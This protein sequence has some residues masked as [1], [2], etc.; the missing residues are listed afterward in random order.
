[1]L[2]S[3][4]SQLNQQ[5]DVT[6]RNGGRIQNDGQLWFGAHQEHA[7]GLEV[8]MTIY[9]GTVDL[10]GGSYPQDNDGIPIVADLAFFY[11]Y[12]FNADECNGCT[13]NLA[14]KNERHTIN[15]KGPGS[16][17]VDES[18]IWIWEQDEPTSPAPTPAIWNG[19][20][21]TYEQLWDRGI[22][23]SGGVSGGD[24]GVNIAGHFVV[25]G[26]AGANDYVVT[27]KDPVAV[28]WD[29]GNGGWD[30]ANWNTGQT[31]SS[32][33]TDGRG[34]PGGHA[35]SIGGGAQVTY[36]AGAIR[37]L[38]P[39]VEN[40]PASITVKEGASLTLASVDTDVDGVWTQYDADLTLDN[41]TFA[42]T[43]GGSSLSGGLMMLG[44]W[45]SRPGQQIDVSVVN[46][47]S[48]EN[49]GQ[50]WFGAHQEH[51]PGLEVTMTINNGSVELTGGSYP[52]DNDGIPIVADLAFFYGY[53]FNADECNGCSANLAAKNEQY[54]INFT[55]PGSIS[56]DESGIWI[57]EQDEPTSPAPTPAIWNGALATYQELW[58]RGILQANGLSGLTGAMF[59]T[60]FSVTGTAG[61]NDYT[62]T[63]LIAPPGLDGDF[64]GDGKVDT[65]DYVVWRKTD[66]MQPGYDEWRANFGRPPG[67]GSAIGQSAVP[68]P[69]ALI[70]LA[71][72]AAGIGCFRRR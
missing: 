36:N 17:T 53:D 47:S 63:S 38:R 8:T 16:V 70:L 23:R 37:D 44:S 12:D 68:E 66:G 69:S 55:G 4:R 10:T 61:A 26:T 34:T 65:A 22:L 42:R 11:G 72:A 2:G 46:G 41:G 49:D 21:A 67:S 31:L 62:L 14:A 27:R 18:G 60:Y 19:A 9:N 15:F 7:P 59:G 13:A 57:W 29:G 6:L 30:S 56:V 45:R 24:G 5:I 52:Q 35:I 25:T 33:T 20:L 54:A 51:A 32:I 40:G 71:A 50:L 39:R 3:W 43:K 48:F 58:D 1:M 64:N 28:V